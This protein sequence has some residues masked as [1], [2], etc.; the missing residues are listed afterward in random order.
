MT[1]AVRRPAFRGVLVVLALTLVAVGIV[2]IGMG[3]VSIPPL[4][5]A[6]LLAHGLSAP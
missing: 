5:V 4:R 2:A 3:T 1:G 6:Q